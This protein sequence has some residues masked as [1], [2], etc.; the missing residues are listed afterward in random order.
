MQTMAVVQQTLINLFKQHDVHPA[1]AM[2]VPLAQAPVF[3][4]MFYGLRRM[5]GAP[6]PQLKEGGF[7]WVTDL[8][9]AD[10]YYILPI[11]SMFLTNI[12]MRVRNCP[13]P[14]FC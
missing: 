11:T 1:R 8:T 6:L 13:L 4:S 14:S 9:L 5:T 2:W 10:P 7:G 12:V 3:L